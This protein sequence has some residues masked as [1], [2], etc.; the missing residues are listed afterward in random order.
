[1]T[2]PCRR[3]SFVPS[4][5]RLVIVA[6]LATLVTQ[7]ATVD[8]THAQ[9]SA[10][11]PPTG[12]TATSVSHNSVTLNWDDPDD[13]SI[14]SYQ[15]LRR[16]TVNQAPG[17]F[18]TVE[19]NTGSAAT[20]YTDNTV[21]AETRYVYRVK[22][23]NSAG[24]SGQS[25]YVNVE[26]LAAPTP[27]VPAQPT[28]L[29]ASSVSHGSVTLTWD[30]P[31]D[32]SI[33]GYQ[34]LRRSRDGDEYGDGLGAAAFAAVIDD[35]GSA[36]TTYTDT[37]VAART[38]YVYRVKAISAGGMS[39]RSTYL[40]VE[41]PEEPAPEPAP[42]P[43]VPAAPAGFAVSSATHDNVTLSWDDPGDGSITGYQ[44]L[45]R[46]RDGGDFRDN[47]GASEF[48]V[49]VDD[50]GFTGDDPHRLVCRG[51]YALRLFGEGQERAGPE[52]SIRHRRRTDPGRSGFTA[53]NGR[54]DGGTLR[55][56]LRSS[57]AHRRGRPCRA[58]RGRVHGGRLL[59][60][61]REPRRG[62]R[63]SRVSGPGEAR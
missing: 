43:S 31:G 59:R 1:M 48:S 58:G 13:S 54:T 21:D 33:T 44:V 50:T 35:T 51:R 27:S 25:N 7:P 39:E 41:T 20:E 3:S 29:T 53:G 24:T 26:T 2:F 57:H 40:N 9:S 18:S 14:T 42:T 52:R 30:D 47:L 61:L 45:R 37:S 12:L 17:T 22:A 8:E 36:A 6:M 62:R 38:R 15:V 28:G 19:S 5:L 16:D 56:R 60:P 55:E 34:V 46:S 63:D 11:A 49:I 23:I 10:P 4:R 32:I